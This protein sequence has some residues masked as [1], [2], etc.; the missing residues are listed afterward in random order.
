MNKFNE[1]IENDQTKC[2]DPANLYFTKV[3][4]DY[5]TA[6]NKL[7]LEAKALM[8][9]FE[10]IMIKKSEKEAFIHGLKKSFDQLNQKYPRCKPLVI[11]I[12]KPAK[13]TEIEIYISGVSQMKMYEVKAVL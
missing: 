12:W 8:R 4:Q 9:K 2:C 7:E 13:S 10:R 3:T 6:K 11:D 5:W 1:L